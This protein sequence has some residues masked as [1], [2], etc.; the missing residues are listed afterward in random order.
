MGWA[1]DLLGGLK[2]AGGVAADAGKA[3][4]G[5]LINEEA[6]GDI[7][8]GGD[9]ATLG[10]WANVALDASMLIPG[11]G[12]VGGAARVGGRLA[13]K[14]LA[15]E[16]AEAATREAAQSAA[17]KAAFRSPVE[18]A[19]RGGLSRAVGKKGGQEAAELGG[20]RVSQ[21]GGRRFGGPVHG[22]A[23]KP[24]A[25]QRAAGKQQAGVGRR[26]GMGQT[27]R[28]TMVNAG[29]TGGANLLA[30]AYDQGMFGGGGGG[31]GDGKEAAASPEGAG[32][33][34]YPGDPY[35]ISVGTDGSM[36]IPPGMAAALAAMFAAQH[37]GTSGMDVVS[38]T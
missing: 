3:V 28:R 10:D 13:A 22:P 4:G 20:R 32:G 38:S 16:A 11:A 5:A 29:L 31:G 35:G 33:L 7:M 26:V 36:T 25:L 9:K 24:N 12:L 19:V 17:L 30:E 8:P 15:Q 37:G 14:K 6:W 18:N 21:L 27:K 23:A 2:S 1:E 34:Y